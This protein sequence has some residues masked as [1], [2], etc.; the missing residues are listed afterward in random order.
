MNQRAQEMLT[1]KETACLFSL[2]AT[3]I[4]PS[5]LCIH[6]RVLI[7]HKNILEG[8]IGRGRA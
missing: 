6:N 2:N 7:L 1:L 8:C 5:V 3:L 4:S